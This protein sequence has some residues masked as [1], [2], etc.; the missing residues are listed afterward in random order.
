MVISVVVITGGQR[1]WSTQKNKEEQTPARANHNSHLTLLT[2][3]VVVRIIN[4]LEGW[5]YSS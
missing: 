5:Y 3:L 4:T 2:Q 1:Q